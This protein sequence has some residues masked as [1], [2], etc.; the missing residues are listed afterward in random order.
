MTDETK[1]LLTGRQLA[2]RNG[3]AV[4]IWL[5]AMAGCW[6][7]IG[8][9]NQSP[10]A[11]GIPKLLRQGFDKN[12]SVTDKLL[13]HQN[14]TPTFPKSAAAK[15]PR[16]NGNVGMSAQVTAE[17]YH[18]D[19]YASPDDTA[20]LSLSMKDIQAFPYQD[21]VYD[22]KCVEG[23]SQITHW[24]GVR[25]ADVIKHYHLGS[26][27]GQPILSGKEPHAYR[28]LG[29]ESIDGKYYVSLDMVSALHPQTLLVWKLND[30]TLPANQGYPLRLIIPIKYGVKS[31]KQLGRIRFSDQLPKDYWGERG[32]DYD[33]TL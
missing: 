7:L 3:V 15:V 30:A 2:I 24:G 19:F 9:I 33:L 21:L 23:W 28:Y 10:T 11:K 25:L 4:F 13:S 18:L 20:A 1:K 12:Q 31:I 22:F 5:M 26:K 6:Y 32:Y 29:L 16:V 14:L 27:I 17:D 8:Y